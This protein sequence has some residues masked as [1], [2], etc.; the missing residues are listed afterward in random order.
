MGG[1]GGGGGGGSQCCWGIV[2]MYKYSHCKTIMFYRHKNIMPLTYDQGLI[3]SPK[4]GYYA[5]R[6]DKMLK[7][8][9]S[10]GKG[11]SSLPKLRQ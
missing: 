6:D 5:S 4:A 10:L 11:S 1:G 3:D 2:L 7:M 9:P 8:C